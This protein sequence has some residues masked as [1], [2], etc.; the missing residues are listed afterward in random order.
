VIMK[1]D[2]VG[3]KSRGLA[4]GLNEFAGYLSVGVTAFL[5]GYLAAEYGLRPVPI[6]LGVAYALLGAVLSIFLVRDTRE[7]VRLEIGSSPHRPTSPISFWE[8]FTPPRSASG[9][10]SLSPPSVIAIYSPHRRQASSTIS[11]TA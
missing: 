10:C 2:L 1:V 7:H 3:P 4:V 11:M 6:Y 9:K 8:V 5:T